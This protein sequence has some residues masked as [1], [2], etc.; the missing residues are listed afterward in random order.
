MSPVSLNTSSPPDRRQ[1][2]SVMLS[3]PSRKWEAGRAGCTPAC[4]SCQL[5][6]AGCVIPRAPQPFVVPARVHR[7]FPFRPAGSTAPIRRASL[8]QTGRT[9]VHA[10]SPGRA[11]W[12][13]RHPR[14]IP[15]FHRSPGSRWTALLN[16]APATS[17]RINTGPAPR[18]PA[19]VVRCPVVTEPSHDRREGETMS[20]L[21]PV[22]CS[23]ACPT[24]FRCHPRLS[25]ANAG[26]PGWLD[27]ESSVRVPALKE[28]GSSG[29][30]ALTRG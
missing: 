23:A 21:S 14:E 17:C 11:C 26:D 5:A 20:G 4:S 13:C 28:Q 3:S 8:P 24:L 27:R 18:R 30:A 1:A 22:V 15:R 10:L 6:L 19:P 16:P 9:L 7:G 25:A 2:P 29:C 12:G